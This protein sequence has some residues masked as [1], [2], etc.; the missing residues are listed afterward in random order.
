MLDRADRVAPMPGRLGRGASKHRD[1]QLTKLSGGWASVHCLKSTPY[2]ASGSPSIS[3]LRFVLIMFRTMRVAKERLIFHALCVLEDAVELTSQGKVQPTASI[4]LALA[5][6]YAFSGGDESA[7][8]VAYEMYWH[9]LTQRSESDA[10][11]AVGFGRKQHLNSA[12]NGL[13]NAA[14]MPRDHLYDAARRKYLERRKRL[15]RTG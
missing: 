9:E 4:R 11:T 7:A 3:T 5:V 6:V 10:R 1:Q 15:G 12:L 8:R 14:G 2:A 13:A